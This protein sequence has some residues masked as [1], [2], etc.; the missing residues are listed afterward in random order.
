M[1]KQTVVNG[2]LVLLEELHPETW[3]G[4]PVTINHP[5]D[6]RGNYVSA[7]SPDM[8]AKFEIGRIF[9]AEIVDG[10]LKAE[11]WLDIEALNVHDPDRDW[12][13]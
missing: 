2:S 1:L 3:N 13:T 6:E 7:N 8:I 10:K 12:E 4:V 9:N 5:T 11:A